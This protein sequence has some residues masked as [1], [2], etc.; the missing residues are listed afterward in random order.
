MSDA[1][2]DPRSQVRVT[3]A[4]RVE[5]AAFRVLRGLLNLLP[6]RVADGIG[7]A[8]GTLAGSILRIRRSVVD[9]NLARAFPDESPEWRARTARES[10][11]HLVREVI[12]TFRLGTLDREKILART[13]IHGDFE[14]MI[15]RGTSGEGAIIV[16]GHMGNWEIGGAASSVRGIPVDA[17]A[18][19]QANLLFDR[20]IVETRRRLGL[21]VITRGRAAR[22][23]MESIRAG[24]VPAIVADQNVRKRGVFVDFF[25]VPAST[26]KGT[27]LFHL[28]TGAPLFA[29]VAV[30]RPPP[31][32][33]YDIHVERIEVEPTGELE[34]DVRRVT[35]A[36]IAF[37]EKWVRR[38]PEQY[39]WQHKRWK[40]R[41]PDEE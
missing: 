32:V 28:R 24:R 31:S 12:A 38:H 4:H 25:G 36:H 22:Q 18:L 3:L 21:N 33:E 1:V 13:H 16:T 39:F 6:H 19:V 23:A 40:T 29:G 7:G 15:R 5:Y 41:P 34:E 10:Y 35:Q 9:E 17:I 8:V 20:D 11:R 14:E 30:R 26:A 27:A 37:L 2:L